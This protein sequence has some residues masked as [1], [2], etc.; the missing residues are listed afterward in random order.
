[1]NASLLWWDNIFRCYCWQISYGYFCMDIFFYWWLWLTTD[2]TRVLESHEPVVTTVN[3]AIVIEILVQKI[4]YVVDKTV[5]LKLNLICILQV[6][7]LADASFVFWIF[8]ALSPCSISTHWSEECLQHDQQ[9]HQ[10]YQLQPY[11]KI[12]KQQTQ[13]IS[14]LQA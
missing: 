3:W 4:L 5:F 1:M 12:K 14:K 10:W 6:V 2:H 13:W 8:L 7:E 11:H 9:C